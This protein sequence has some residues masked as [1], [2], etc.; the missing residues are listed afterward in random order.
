MRVMGIGAHPDDLEL[1][2]AGTLARYA[3]TGHQIIMVSAT[4][5][6]KGHVT[7]PPEEIRVIRREELRRSAAII[8]AESHCLSIPDECLVNDLAARLEM[9]EVI[10]QFKP[11]LIITHDPNDCHVDHRK[12]AELVFE[13]ASLSFVPSVK[14]G[15]PEHPVFMPIYYMENLLSFDFI[16][17]E[18]VDISETFAIKQQMLGEHKSQFVTMSE[19]IGSDM[20]EVIEITA[21]FRGM[22]VGA[23]YAEAF[24]LLRTGLRM[25]TKR[26]LP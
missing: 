17:E 6:D 3:Q 4:N 21:R 10:R 2:C 14:T 22:Q 18:F 19:R 1:Q 20:R 16:P 24:R 9:V 25:P 23:K 13:A 5:G 11:D 12:T 26:L 7:L 8:G 15:S